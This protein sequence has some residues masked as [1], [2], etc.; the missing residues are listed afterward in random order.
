MKL[1]WCIRLLKSAVL[2]VCVLA[3]VRM[4]LIDWIGALLL[5]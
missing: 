1:S 2:A 5:L 3:N 4:H